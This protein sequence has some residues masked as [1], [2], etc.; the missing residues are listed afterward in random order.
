MRKVKHDYGNTHFKDPLKY[1]E[2]KIADE[3]CYL[4]CG[5]QTGDR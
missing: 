2:S 3:N 5:L 4:Y 1:P